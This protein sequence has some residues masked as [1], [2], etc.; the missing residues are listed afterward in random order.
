MVYYPGHFLGMSFEYSDD[1]FCV[2]VEDGGVAVVASGQDL[3]G[4][5]CMDVQGQNPR[6]TR[7]VQTLWSCQRISL[8]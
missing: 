5:S 6:D 4:V 2:L 8:M 1:L 3:A 7:T